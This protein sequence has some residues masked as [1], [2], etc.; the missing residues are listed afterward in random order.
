MQ[1]PLAGAGCLIALAG[2][3]ASFGLVAGPSIGL[4]LVLGAWTIILAVVPT[5][6]HAVGFAGLALALHASRARHASRAGAGAAGADGSGHRIC[7]ARWLPASM[8]PRAAL[9]ALWRAVGGTMVVTA[10]AWLAAGALEL[11]EPR[12]DARACGGEASVPS[13][14]R[15]AI[16]LSLGAEL[17]VLGVLALWPPLR[18]RVQSRLAVISEG[19]ISEGVAALAR[20]IAPCRHQ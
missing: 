3:M 6:A 5:N 18:L 13:A 14:S 2:I 16:R 19:A 4:G 8:P 9:D 20:A 7:A 17:A 11:I 12:L 15:A 10:L 1:M